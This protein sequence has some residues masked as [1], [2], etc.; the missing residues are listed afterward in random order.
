M[1]GHVSRYGTVRES[2]LP[3]MPLIE[4]SVESAKEDLSANSHSHT[5]NVDIRNV[6]MYAGR[7]LNHTK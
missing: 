6:H 2:L 7:V 4:Q 1:P 5:W 3:R